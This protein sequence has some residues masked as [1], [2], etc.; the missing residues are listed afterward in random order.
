MRRQVEKLFATSQ[1]TMAALSIAGASLAA[2]TLI[3]LLGRNANAESVTVQI[4]QGKI[5]GKPINNG[6]VQAYLGIP[7][8]APPIGPQRWAPPQ[9]PSQWKGVMDASRYGHHC[10]QAPPG[11]DVELQD[12]SGS[13]D[14]LSLNV[15][16]PAR[17]NAGAKLPVM[18]W[19]HGGGYT[20]GGSS[21][22]RL[23]G[24][25]LPGKGIVLVTINYRLGVFGFLALPE[26]STERGGRSGN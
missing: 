26:F 18:F 19:I 22:P 12:A 8:A 17:D 1:L 16:V 4:E 20:G 21:E 6:A 13:E 2:A 7:Y 14:C 11:G 15:F 9:P 23:N 10:M 5:Q 25:F 3:L 24:D